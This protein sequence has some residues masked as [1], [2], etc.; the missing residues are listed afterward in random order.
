MHPGGGEAEIKGLFTEEQM[1]KMF[2][3]AALLACLGNFSYAQS[4]DQYGGNLS[5]VGTNTGAWHAEKIGNRWFLVTPAG[6]GMFVV[7]LSLVTDTLGGDHHR[8]FDAVYLQDAS[9][10]FTAGLG[11][12][13]EDPLKSDVVMGSGATLRNV[14]DTIYIG[15]LLPS[16]TGVY[17]WLSQLGVGGK[18]T[19]YYSKGP[20]SW[21]LLQGTGKPYGTLSSSGKLNADGSYYMD[22]GDYLAPDPVTGF[23]AGG[24]PNANFI[25][26][27]GPKWRYLGGDNS[28]YPADFVPAALSMDPTPKFYVKGVVT[29]AFTTAPILNQL[30]DRSGYGDAV[31]SK[32]GQPN[33]LANGYHTSWAQVQTQRL[34]SWGFNTAGYYSYRYMSEAENLGGNRLP[35]EAPAKLSDWAMRASSPYHIKNV[36]YRSE[37]PPG[38]GKLTWQSKTADVFDSGYASTI[39]S[40]VK[41]L[42]LN[43]WEFL[44][45]EEADDL[46]GLNSLSH[47]HLGYMTL[48]VNPY[49]SDDTSF[50]VTYTD[51]RLYS[52]YALR[53]FFRYRYRDPSDPIAPWVFSNTPPFYSYSSAPSGLEL[54]ALNNLNA[55][56]GTSYTV[57]GTSSGDLLS[58]TNAWGTGTGF[59]DERGKGVFYPANQSCGNLVYAKQFTNPSFP[60]VRKDLDDFVEVFAAKHASGICAAVK[61]N[62]KSPCLMPYYNPPDP[63]AK[64][65]APYVDFFWMNASAQDLSRVYDIGGKPVMKADYSTADPDSADGMSGVIAA[66]TYD[67]ARNRTIIYDPN[68]R[69]IFRAGWPIHFPNLPA[70]AFNG[71]QCAWGKYPAPKVQAAFWNTIEVDGDYRCVGGAGTVFEKRPHHLDLRTQAQ[72]AQKMIGD[73]DAALNLKGLDG[74]HFLMGWEHWGLFDNGAMQWNE[75]YN[76]GLVTPRD[77]AY[78]GVEAAQAVGKDADGRWIGGEDRDY[79]DLIGPLSNYLKS[80]Y[81]RIQWSGTPP[82]PDTTPPTVSMTAP[83]DGANLIGTAAVSGTASD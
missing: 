58:G 50:G 47:E 7:A 1:R 48:A 46:F 51:P 34:R 53:D 55:A 73:L 14:G 3:S 68:L 9:G 30:V 16:F 72:R 20:N 6:H 5:I 13:A 21:A 57:W 66:I 38:S 64:G 29:Q 54:T 67:S 24:N 15:S 4:L 32:Y 39:N 59:M 77:N 41:S 65:A 81:Y 79:G 19:W 28:V 22:V 61:G 62:T 76:F 26:F 31:M 80:I 27:F 78:D 36:I 83:A 70:D 2:W 49:R 75:T 8:A 17:F 60:A 35:D 11:R 33:T 71:G 42:S 43:S 44:I 52:K 10:N 63:A 74:Y 82:S 12:P 25:R 56:W 40:E 23:G 18:I 45:P 69:Y 37:C